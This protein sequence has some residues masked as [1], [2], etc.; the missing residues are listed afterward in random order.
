[1][2]RKDL[3]ELELNL[4]DG[5]GRWSLTVPHR[6]VERFR[7]LGL[8]GRGERQTVELE[9]AVAVRAA[10][11]IL[12]RINSFGGTARQVREAVTLL[13]EV[14]P[15]ERVFAAAPRLVGQ[16]RLTR[17]GP[18]TRLALEMAAHEETE[19]WAMEG[20]LAVL[21]AAWREAE[22]I[23]SIAD[24]LLIPESVENWIRQHRETGS[25][26]PTE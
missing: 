1:M 19:R 23:A 26:K 7:F 20:E 4:L 25:K 6:A 10:S 17:M 24:R 8:R 2:I 14:G 5:A 15:P 12:P 9:G 11:Y 22:E 3:K 21:E 16:T 18:E 13:E